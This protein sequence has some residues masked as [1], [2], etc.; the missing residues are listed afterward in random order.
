MRHFFWLAVLFAV[1]LMLLE[2]IDTYKDLLLSV[3]MAAQAT[4][5][6]HRQAIEILEGQE[7]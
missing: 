3:Q 1:T 5:D 2:R 6:N 7:P 4:I